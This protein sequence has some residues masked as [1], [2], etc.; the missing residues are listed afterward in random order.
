MDVR[1]MIAIPLP[2]STIHR[3]GQNRRGKKSL[4]SENRDRQPPIRVPLPGTPGLDACVDLADHHLYPERAF[5][6]STPTAPE[7]PGGRAAAMRPQRRR[8]LHRERCSG[9]CLFLLTYRN[10]SDRRRFPSPDHRAGP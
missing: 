7:Y 10:S 1:S 8:A 4:P 6:Q 9:S 5:S 2:D 3:S